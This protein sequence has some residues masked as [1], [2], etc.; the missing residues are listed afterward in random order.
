MDSGGNRTPIRIGR[1]VHIMY[2]QLI[3]TNY[4][5][6]SRLGSDGLWKNRFHIAVQTEILI[7]D[8]SKFS[9][10]ETEPTIYFISAYFSGLKAHNPP[11]LP[12]E[13]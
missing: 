4:R 2:L 9:A 7:I 5:K 12:S 13:K 1:K 6:W 8:G 11:P 10:S 3:P